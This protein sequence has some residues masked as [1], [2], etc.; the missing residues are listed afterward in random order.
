MTIYT[1]I[2][3][4]LIPAVLGTTLLFSLY[5]Q[6]KDRCKGYNLHILPRHIWI[7]N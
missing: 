1:M 7:H 2:L 6:A 5:R 4:A 3:K